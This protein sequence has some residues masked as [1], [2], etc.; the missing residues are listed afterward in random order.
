MT[1]KLFVTVSGQ[2]CPP[3]HLLLFLSSLLLFAT[4]SQWAGDAYHDFVLFATFA[5]H[6]VH[7][8]TYSIL[9]RPCVCMSFQCES[10][11][12]SISYCFHVKG[13]GCNDVYDGD[14]DDDDE[15]T[16]SR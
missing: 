6:T 7:C 14:D 8:S 15:M 12:P 5:I 11:I 4:V 1:P 3:L 13:G 9:V 16:G 2:G 10:L